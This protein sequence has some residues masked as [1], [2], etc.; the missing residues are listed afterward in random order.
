[1]D[2]ADLQRHA[3]HLS[4]VWDFYIDKESIPPNRQ[5]GRWLDW[6]PP[7]RIEEAIKSLAKRLSKPQP[8]EGGA[9]GLHR[10]VTAALIGIRRKAGEASLAKAGEML[11]D[12]VY[13]PVRP[14][15]PTPRPRPVKP[16]QVWTPSFMKEWQAECEDYRLSRAAITDEIDEED[17]DDD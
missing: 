17:R 14:A 6:N 9:E 15:S 10:Y 7:E 13:T 1:M 11:P 3:A 2:I 12:P 5:W 16:A 8:M 4:Q